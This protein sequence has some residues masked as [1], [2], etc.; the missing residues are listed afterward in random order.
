MTTEKTDLLLYIFKIIQFLIDEL[1][2]KF[3]IGFLDK[4]EKNGA[5]QHHLTSWKVH[6]GLLDVGV[7]V[8]LYG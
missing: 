7:Y 3:T 4:A 5:G 1:D 8:F 6:V 2:I